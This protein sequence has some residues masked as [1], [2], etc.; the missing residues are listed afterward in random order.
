M[1]RTAAGNIGCLLL[2]IVSALCTVAA[3]GRSMATKGQP[4]VALEM[5]MLEANVAKACRAELD[6]A[7][8]CIEARL[9]RVEALKMAGDLAGALKDLKACR[10][11]DPTQFA[12]LAR[13]GPGRDLRMLGLAVSKMT[14]GDRQVTLA[15]SSAESGDREN[16]RVLL[17]QGIATLD[18]AI[19]DIQLLRLG[20]SQPV[21]D[22]LTGLR[23]KVR[24][25]HIAGLPELSLRS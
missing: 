14:E 9:A 13:T 23:S 19:R 6:D 18:A 4:V 21:Q 16:S 11:V 8:G 5:Q 7:V 22:L 17:Q 10:D 24:Y 1:S 25:K 12:P 3:A 15:E 20:T 2:L